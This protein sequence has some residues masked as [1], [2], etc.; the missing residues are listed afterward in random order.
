MWRDSGSSDS[1]QC[2]STLSPRS[3]AN[4]HSSR[5]DSRAFGHGALEMGDAADHVDA[6][7]DRAAQVG[8]RGRAAQHAVLRER[9]QLQVEVG[10]DAA[11]HFEQ[12]LNRQQPV[13][14]D[15]DVRADRQQAARDRPVA[16]LHRA[17]DQ[18]L[19]LQRRF[20][21]APQCDPFEQGAG[22][23]HA[24]QAVA[25]G[26]V[27]VEVGVDERR[28]DQVALR[29]DLA[30]A[31][32]RQLLA[33]RGDAPVFDRDVDLAPAVGQAG[34]ANDEIHYRSCVHWDASIVAASRTS[35]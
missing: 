10:R 5:T 14:A 3:A 9:D 25:E 1:S 16:V 4:S 26:G 35:A 8:E 13:V 32:Q 2:M 20:E 6:H 11:P 21:F 15:V 24:R 17:L 29:V 22:L 18:R 19:L 31:A 28:R 12:R 23:V 33:H 7:L 30:R 34:I 27:H